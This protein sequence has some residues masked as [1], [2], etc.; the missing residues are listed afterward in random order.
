MRISDALATEPRLTRRQQDGF[1]SSRQGAD[2]F[3]EQAAVAQHEPSRIGA[4]EVDD[5]VGQELEYT[6]L[7][8]VRVAQVLHRGA[9]ARPGLGVRVVVR[10]GE[11]VRLRLG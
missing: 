8:E 11:P 9:V 10:L 1:G 5:S 3:T 4:R 2:A 6:I 7:A